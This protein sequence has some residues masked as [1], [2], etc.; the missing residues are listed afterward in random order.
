MLSVLIYT[1]IPVL[2]LVLAS[3]LALLRTPGPK[4]VSLFQHFAAGVVFSAVA[5][6]LL[7]ELRA[8][9]SPLPVAIGFLAGVMAML[10]IDKFSDKAG[11]VIPMAVDLFIDGMLV[12]IGFAAGKEGGA[13]LLIGLTLETTSL[14]LGM[15]PSLRKNGLARLRVLAIAG[16]LG[17][18]IWTG[19]GFGHFAM[20]ASGAI[21]TAIL[22]FGVAALLYLVTE[23]LLSEAHEETEDTSV[24]TAGFFVGFLIPFLITLTG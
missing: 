20:K 23:E 5:L 19:A 24:V 15:S 4:L 8:A 14:G 21:L 10:I 12:A 7:P 17:L 22:S 1:A 16:G 13:I 6:E 2:A 11:M 18:A 9:D 3:A